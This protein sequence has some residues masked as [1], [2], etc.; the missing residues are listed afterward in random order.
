[1]KNLSGGQQRTVAIAR[2]ISAK[3]KIIIDD[4]PTAGLGLR[5]VS[6][7]LDL[8]A[9]LRSEGISII[10]IS[11]RLQDIFSIAD[12]IMIMRDGQ[13]VGCKRVSETTPE[14]IARK[15]VGAEFVDFHRRM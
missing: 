15:V 14:E 8:L 6:Q 3:T 11:H 1:V 7:L 4:E 10:L 13:N 5:Q 9:H 12:R 2:S